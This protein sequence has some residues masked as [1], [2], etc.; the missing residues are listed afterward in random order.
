MDITRSGVESDSICVARMMNT[1]KR[2]AARS[3]VSVRTWRRLSYTSLSTRK[4]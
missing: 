1:R 2:A 3:R 4:A